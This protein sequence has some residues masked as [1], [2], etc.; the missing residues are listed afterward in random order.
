MPTQEEDTS[1]RRRLPRSHNG[2]LTCRRRKVRC[3][4]QRPRCSHCERLN[5]Q[6][7]WRPIRLPSRQPQSQDQDPQQQ[8]HLR[9]SMPL[10]LAPQQQASL[11]FDF[12]ND[13]WQDISGFDLDWSSDAS[14]VLRD[15]QQWPVVLDVDESIPGRAYPH[16][17]NTRLNDSV[18]LG[19]EQLC[20]F[21][22]G[23]WT[24]A[25][26]DV[27]GERNSL[28]EHFL[29]SIVPPILAGVE[30]GPRWTS[31][32]LLLI[33]L[34]TASGMV[35]DAVA[36]FS[37][38]HSSDTDQDAAS[39]PS[40]YYGR[41][42]EQVVHHIELCNGKHE[43]DSE[44]LQHALVA[45]F[46][47]SYSALLCNHTEDAHRLLQQGTQLLRM[48]SSHQLVPTVK[49]LISW[50]RLVDGRASSAGGSGAFLRETESPRY[51][52]S[53]KG[54][55]PPEV[56]TARSATSVTS[57]DLEEVLF[58]MLYM[59][60]LVFYQ[61]VQ[62]IMARVSDMDKWHRS[63]G[64]V[65]DE[66]EVMSAAAIIS[67]DLTTLESGRPALMDFAVAGTLNDS[68]LMAGLSSALVR[69]Y[70]TYWAN[71]HAGHIHLHRVAYTHLEATA[72]VLQARTAIKNTARLLE[73]SHDQLPANFIWPLLMA[74]SEEEDATERHWMIELIR[75]MQSGTTNAG[76]IA[77]VLEEV[78]RRQDSTKR[79]ADIRQTSMDLY[80]KSFAVF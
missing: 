2:C 49:R 66:T 67:N 55:V 23:S 39:I 26:S 8:S 73:E 68:H 22:P 65:K 20:H 5:L 72:D 29:A 45:I 15:G 47:L 50:I 57:D 51:D 14:Q 27:D 21:S 79:R 56:S 80:N 46:F 9:E 63:R 64:T 18:Q 76:P 34:A 78:H 4:E 71:Y 77:C 25:L 62:S 12:N 69:S 24:S 1:S 35:L 16:D 19:P 38:L 37:A 36:A 31:A 33:S 3:N 42:K 53:A 48:A 32:K 10:L 61:R 44:G 52:Y 54:N 13:L 43:I 28:V 11:S 6:C 41:S 30:V 70:R 40:V 58:D 60:G 75:G 59:P 74:C 7:T 17:S